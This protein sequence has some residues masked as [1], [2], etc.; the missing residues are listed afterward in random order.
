MLGVV[1]VGG[2][3][4]LGFI[5]VGVEM[6]VFTLVSVQVRLRVER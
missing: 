3:E 5:K 6:D 2:G 1:V 4:G